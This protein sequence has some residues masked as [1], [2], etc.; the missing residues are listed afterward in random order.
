MTDRRR[1]NSSVLT[2]RPY[3][4]S[5]SGSVLRDEMEHA[6]NYALPSFVQHRLKE[7]SAR[8][9]RDMWG[10]DGSGRWERVVDPFASG[11]FRRDDNAQKA[12][13]KRALR[14]HVRDVLMESTHVK[15]VIVRSATRRGGK[16]T[17]EFHGAR[18]GRSVPHVDQEVPNGSGQV[19]LMDS[20]TP[21]DAILFLRPTVGVQGGPGHG[22]QT[23][24][25]QKKMQ[26]AAFD[27]GLIATVFEIVDGVTS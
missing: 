9:W 27:D 16:L 1:G 5:V 6:E 20:S 13:P 26:P 11:P 10:E 14:T 19:L 7:A 25:G 22:E 15:D 24:G 21:L 3:A 23:G 4:F 18:A 8:M 17:V 12:T 2:L